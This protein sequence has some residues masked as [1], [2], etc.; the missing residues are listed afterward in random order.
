MSCIYS[1]DINSFNTDI[2][3]LDM[4]TNVFQILIVVFQ[5]KVK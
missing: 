4:A 3:D 2:L 5:L 1:Q